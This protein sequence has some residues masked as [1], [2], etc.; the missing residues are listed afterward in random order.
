MKNIGIS[1]DLASLSREELEQQ[2]MRL[3]SMVDEM[4]VKLSWY[5]EQY[6]LS[7]KAVPGT[8]LINLLKMNPEGVEF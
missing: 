2:N 1:R 8:Q 6:R 4:A 5:E 3:L 7:N